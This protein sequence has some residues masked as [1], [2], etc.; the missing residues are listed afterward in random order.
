MDADA[1]ALAAT[2]AK[3]ISQLFQVGVAVVVVFV[4]VLLWSMAVLG[5]KQI[6]NILLPANSVNSSFQP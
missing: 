6:L 3:T 4:I 1:V 5:G 2:T